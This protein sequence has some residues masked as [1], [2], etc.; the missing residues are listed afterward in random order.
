MLPPMPSAP[1]LLNF[2]CSTNSDPGFELIL[3]RMFVRSLPECSGFNP[4]VSVSHVAEFCV[5]LS[6]VSMEN[7]DKSPALLRVKRK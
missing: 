6:V 5:N 2:G 1:D 7:A 3:I 4:H